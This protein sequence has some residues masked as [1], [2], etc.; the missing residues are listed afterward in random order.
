MIVV[1]E[2]QALLHAIAEAEVPPEMTARTLEPPRCRD[3]GNLLTPSIDRGRLQ[4]RCRDCDAT[5]ES[6]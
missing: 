2:E 4:Y 1:Q 6:P 3:C 5:A